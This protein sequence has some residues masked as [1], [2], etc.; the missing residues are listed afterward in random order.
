MYEKFSTKILPVMF[1]VLY[2]VIEEGNGKEWQKFLVAQKEA[3]AGA[4]MEIEKRRG[5]LGDIYD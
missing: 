5:V 2:I 3:M 4:L 1:I